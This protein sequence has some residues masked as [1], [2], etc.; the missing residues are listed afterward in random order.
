MSQRTGRRAGRTPG[1]ARVAV[2]R[3][4]VGERTAWPEDLLRLLGNPLRCRDRPPRRCRDAHGRRRAEAPRHPSLPAPLPAAR[5]DAGDD[6]AAGHRQRWQRRAVAGHPSRL[7][8]AAAQAAAHPA[9]PAAAARLRQRPSLDARR[10]R[11]ARQDVG[12]GG[13][14]A[15]GNQRRAG[16]PAR[17]STSRPLGA[18]LPSCAG[19]PRCSASSAATPTPGWRGASACPPSP[20]RGSGRSS[21]WRVPPTAASWSRAARCASCWAIRSPRSTGAA[22]SAARRPSGSAAPWAWRHDGRLSPGRPRSSAAWAGRRTPP[23]PQ[24]PAAARGG[25]RG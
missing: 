19:A 21:G 4:P 25:D 10:D 24:P 14:A 23:W 22:A 11:H 18:G 15:T 20:S 5:M 16:H 2:R 6:R 7:R 13:R 1:K 12:P 9:P 8:Q 17:R 3:R